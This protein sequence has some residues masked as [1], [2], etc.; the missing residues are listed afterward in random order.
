MEKQ[1]II[2]FIFFLFSIPLF[3][4]RLI[5]EYFW[6]KKVTH[7]TL[8]LMRFSWIYIILILTSIICYSFFSYI[9]IRSLISPNQSSYT[10]IASLTFFF[11]IIFILSPTL[12]MNIL[13]SKKLINDEIDFYTLNF[14]LPILS[15][16]KDIFFTILFI[17]VISFT[18][19][20]IKM[21]HSSPVMSIIFLSIF[22]ALPLSETY[23]A[24]YRFINRSLSLKILKERS[25][26]ILNLKFKDFSNYLDL[27]QVLVFEN[28]LLPLSVGK[29]GKNKTFF[30]IE[31]N[32]A[33]VEWINHLKSSDVIKYNFENY[34]T[35]NLLD[36]GWLPKKAKI[37][38]EEIFFPGRK[39]YIVNKPVENKIL[40][41]LEK[42]FIDSWIE[43]LI[44]DNSKTNVSNIFYKDL[45]IVE[46][47][48]FNQILKV[49]NKKNNKVINISYTL[50]ENPTFVFLSKK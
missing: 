46:V 32:L 7:S 21:E 48:N 18:F 4:G 19:I 50:F 39:I 30:N 33:D 12:I 9:G 5:L 42:Y 17:W 43:K 35:L 24:F 36:S 10:I 26:K 41:N 47:D 20:I 44:T 11:S 3:F 22:F 6:C 37:S 14:S 27:E 31:P 28:K 38:F 8:Y 25:E 45:E 29:I 16:C 1:I 34:N 40:Q 23:I 49:H 2:Y 13:I 15:F